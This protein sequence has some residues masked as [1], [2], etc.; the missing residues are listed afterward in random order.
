MIRGHKET[1]LALY[2]DDPEMAQKA[3][4]KFEKELV[5]KREQEWMRLEDEE[6]EYDDL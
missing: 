5:L 1:F 4:D 6:V 3:I 2:P